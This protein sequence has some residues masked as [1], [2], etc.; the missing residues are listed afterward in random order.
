ME[1]LKIEMSE[2]TPKVEE[3]QKTVTPAAETP[4][5][6]EEPRYVRIEDLEKIH[7]AINNTRDYNNRQLQELTRRLES[8]TPKPIS[9]GEP[10]LDKIVQEDWKAGVELVAERLIEKR[11]AKSQAETEANQVARILDESKQKVMDRHKELSDPES[12][13]AKIFL[14]VLDENPDFKT[15]P[16]GP[17]LAAY[18]M[19]NRLK[20]HDKVESET[21]RVQKVSQVKEIRAKGASVPAGTPAG[22]KQGY[23][24]TK[25]DMDF[26]RLN[27]I[28]PENYKR[29]KGQKEA[30]V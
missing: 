23:A 1:G 9:T 14:K 24:M 8:V 10:D 5:P 2:T 3:T 20:T 11:L 27:G 22:T 29:F 4:K 17:L 13:K 7:Q 16:R 15:N 6:K 18:E 19:E 12:E 25:Q 30:T 26:C 21:E 28:N